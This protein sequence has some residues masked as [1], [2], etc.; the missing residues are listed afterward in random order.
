MDK[1][2]LKIENKRKNLVPDKILTNDSVTR[3]K[4]QCEQLTNF[5]ERKNLQTSTLKKQ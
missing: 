2:M 3:T 5:N 1:C 4:K